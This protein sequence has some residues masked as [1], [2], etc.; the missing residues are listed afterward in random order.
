MPRKL[1]ILTGELEAP[2]L[3]A[4]LSRAAG[5]GCEISAI[6]SAL[7][8]QAQHAM[9][10]SGVRLLSFCSSVIVPEAI[11]AALTL[12][13][14]NVHPGAP[15]HPGIYP[16]AYAVYDGVRRFA[17][18]AHVMAER[19]DS[20]AIIRTD[21]FDVPSAW[22]REQLAERVYQAALGIFLEIAHL[23]MT[24]DNPL[25]RN[26]ETWSGTRRTR[27]HYRAMCQSVSDVE[28]TER[29]RRAFAPDF[30]TVAPN[31]TAES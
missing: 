28:E 11:L 17:A 14:Y 7:E 15:S 22:G 9:E 6:A 3:A 20:G 2:Q 12:E 10:L 27:A 21:W 24:D 25:P 29:R 26:G 13:P 4:T 1:L 23:C 18:T 8:L 16:E 5:S 19:V 30:G 31:I